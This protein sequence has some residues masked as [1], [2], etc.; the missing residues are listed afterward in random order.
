MFITKEQESMLEGEQG[1]TISK[2]MQLIIKIGEANGAERLIPI[3]SAQIAGVSYL[4]VGDAIFSFFHDLLQDNVK[5]KVPSWLNPAGMDLKQT[6]SMGIDKK[7][8]EK[9]LKIIDNYVRLGIEPTLTCTPYLVGNAPAFGEHIAW[10]ESSAVS[11]ANS[12][13]GARTNREGGPSS[14]ASAITGLTAEYGL[15]VDENRLPHISI[16]V[17]TEL[18]SLS[19]FA[20]LGYWFGKNFGGRIPLFTGIKRLSIEEAKNLAAAMAAAGSVA[21]YHVMGV[22]PEKDL[23]S[24]SKNLEKIEFTTEEKNDFY[25][26]FNDSDGS[27]ELVTVGCPH[28]SVKEISSINKKLKN[29]RLKKNVKLWIFTSRQVIENTN[30]QDLINNLRRIKGVSIFSDTCMVVSPSIRN[31][32]HYIATNSAKAAFYLMKNKDTH[33]I[34]K[35]LDKIIEDVVE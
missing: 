23:Y 31:K 27:I 21:L 32:F 13:Y 7:F 29:K 24:D 30:N 18:E 26:Q 5:V 33:V 16:E 12:Y 25:N 8:A 9:Q 34:C 15:H 4:T 17:N 20:G 3:K 35:P 10:S 2:L 28:A 6:K 14:L 19:D 1:Y 11:M 22:T